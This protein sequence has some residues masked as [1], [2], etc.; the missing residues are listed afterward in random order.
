EGEPS[1]F[2]NLA[3]DVDVAEVVVENQNRLFRFRGHLWSSFSVRMPRH[4][5][6][7][8][9]VVVLHGEL[10][11]PTGIELSDG[12]AIDLLPGGL[13]VEQGRL[14]GAAAPRELL[15]GDQ[16]I[17]ARLAD[18][19]ANAI[20]GFDEREVPAGSGLRARIQDGRRVRGPALPTV[21]ERRQ[22]LD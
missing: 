14:K 3:F 8:H 10:H 18:V 13:V 12:R 9:E 2:G 6:R 1:V 15:V 22:R 16:Q 17:D 4:P 7:V 5:L 19:D 21:A 20:A 11:A